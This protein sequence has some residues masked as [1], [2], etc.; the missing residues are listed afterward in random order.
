MNKLFDKLRQWFRRKQKQT[1]GSTPANSS[2]EELKAGGG[3]RENME[4]MRQDAPFRKP[5]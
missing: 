4:R 5:Q 2:H 1:D 3:L